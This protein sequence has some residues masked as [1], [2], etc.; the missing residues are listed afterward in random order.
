[1]N[2]MLKLLSILLMLNLFLYAGIKF[3][4]SADGLNQ[5]DPT[6]HFQWRGDLVDY[7]MERSLDDMA[8]DYKDGF[9][10]YGANFSSNFRNFPTQEG[11]QT[12]GQGGIIFLDSL[13]V[14]WSF[15][16][17]LANVAFAPLA[18]FFNYDM[19]ILIGILIGIP[20]SIIYVATIILAIRG[21]SD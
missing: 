15:F 6:L 1:M 13:K 2:T 3:I 11:G 19:P 12:I 17:T 20:L 8:S 5:P 14:V 7:F 18:F 10:N 21:V 16:T 4:S 9:T